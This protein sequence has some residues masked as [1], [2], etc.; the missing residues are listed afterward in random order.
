MP[1]CGADQRVRG[2]HTRQHFILQAFRIVIAMKGEMVAGREITEQLERLLTQRG[3]RLTTTSEFEIARMIKEVSIVP[4][5]TL[6]LVACSAFA[7]YCQRSLTAR[8]A[9]QAH[10]YVAR[11]YDEELKKDESLCEARYEMPDG[12]F[13][14]LGR[15]RFKCAESLFQPSLIGNTCALPVHEQ[16]CSS[17][18]K[19]DVDIRKDFFSNIV[20]SGGTTL[21]PGFADRLESEV[22]RFYTTL[23]PHTM[24]MMWC[25]F[26][27]ACAVYHCHAFQAKS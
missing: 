9:A 1:C 19:C 5:H 27:A 23:T 13:I 22:S 10:G 17:I 15:E 20:L 4:S 12:Q 21:L 11:D 25:G 2:C 6:S 8:H 16:L 7:H 24:A 14:T 18:M 3:V 26:D